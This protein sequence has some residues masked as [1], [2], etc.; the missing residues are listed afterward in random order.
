[1]QG[2]VFIFG[3]VLAKTKERPRNMGADS[4]KHWFV[5][6]ARCCSTRCGALGWSLMQFR[7]GAHPFHDGLVVRVKNLVAQEKQITWFGE[8]FGSLEKF[9]ISV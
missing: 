7:S 8:A 6:P 2:Y 5:K 3:A 4:Q 9:Y 1:M